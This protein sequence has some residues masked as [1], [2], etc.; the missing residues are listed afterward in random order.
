VATQFAVIRE[1]DLL[2]M[3]EE[4]DDDDAVVWVERN[5]DSVMNRFQRTIQRRVNN[6]NRYYTIER[7]NVRS[8]WNNEKYIEEA[9][10]R[11][12]EECGQTFKQLHCV[13]TLQQMPKFDPMVASVDTDEEVDHSGNHNKFGMAMG[14][15]KERPIKIVTTIVNRD[16][17][18]YALR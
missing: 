6:F 9:G 10:K 18:F 11:Y 7:N 4:K 5:A 17:P 14:L 15:D 1:A 13:S 2:K 8:G 12:V 16:S 3:V